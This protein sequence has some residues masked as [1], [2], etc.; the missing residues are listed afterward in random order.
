MADYD[1]TIFLA[2]VA[3]QADWYEDMVNHLE[4]AVKMKAD[5]LS[6]EERNLLSVG[7]KNLIGSW[8]TALRSIAGIE[9]NTKYAH[10][11]DGL[12]RYK[13]KIENELYD[14]CIRVINLIK[15]SIITKAQTPE[16]KAFFEKMIGDYY[17]YIAESAK[18]S[19]L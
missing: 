10:F 13:Q 14:K 11:N 7:F 9:Q 12:Q 18:G 4:Q 2:W 1:E 5:D 6:G 19:R 17:W 3:E 8:R 15:S 16:S